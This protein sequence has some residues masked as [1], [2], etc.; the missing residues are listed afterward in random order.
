MGMAG[1]FLILLPKP[2][3]WLKDTTVVI[4]S[5]HWSQAGF[6]SRHYPSYLS[7]RVSR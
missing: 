3:Y 2:R 4:L 7:A 1:W 5:K 6:K